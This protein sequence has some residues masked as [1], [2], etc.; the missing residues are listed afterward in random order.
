MFEEV[1]EGLLKLQKL[2]NLQ[3]L[4]IAQSW[5]KS[6]QIYVKFELH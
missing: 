1:C 3:K 4:R 2:Q 6:D 5:K